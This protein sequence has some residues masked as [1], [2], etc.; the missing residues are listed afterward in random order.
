VSLSHNINC[1]E[2]LKNKSNSFRKS[3]ALLRK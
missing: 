1:Y 2:H 3:Q